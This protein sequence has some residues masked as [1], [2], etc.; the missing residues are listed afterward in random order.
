MVAY[1]LVEDS[2]KVIGVRLKLSNIGVYVDTT[3]ACF[4]ELYKSRDISIKKGKDIKVYKKGSTF[5]SRE[6]EAIVLEVQDIELLDKLY[7]GDIQNTIS[8]SNLYESNTRDAHKKI[9]SIISSINKFSGMMFVYI[10][11]QYSAQLKV[12]IHFSTV[13]DI[14]DFALSY[15]GE[16]YDKIN[17]GSKKYPLS[18]E[19]LMSIPKD[20]FVSIG[21]FSIELEDDEGDDVGYITGF[22]GLSDKGYLF[23]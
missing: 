17:I 14:V 18:K 20:K 12:D 4:K 23:D 1:K 3:I 16:K 9:C 21:D 13:E 19:V 15:Y 7:C 5:I 2:T 10:S 8:V 11:D 22:F 6:N